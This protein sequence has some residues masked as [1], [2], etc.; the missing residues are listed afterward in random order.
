MTLL[1]VFTD[2]PAELLGRPPL[3]TPNH[4]NFLDP[5]PGNTFQLNKN[6]H[7]KAAKLKRQ[8]DTC[9]MS[10]NAEKESTIPATIAQSLL[11]LRIHSVKSRNSFC[12]PFVSR[13]TV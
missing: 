11:A 6:I 4:P 9:W 10:L 7:N 5:K 3:L 13:A 8:I 12:L 2:V 1:H